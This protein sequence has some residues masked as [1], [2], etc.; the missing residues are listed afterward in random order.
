MEPAGQ[1]STSD[2]ESIR[3]LKAGYDTLKQE[4]HRVIVG[5]ERVLDEL[6]TAIFSRGHALLVGVPGLAKTLMIRTLSQTLSLSFNRVQFTPDLMPSDI[7]GTEVID[8][9]Q[10]V[11]A[12]ERI[13]MPQEYHRIVAGLALGP[14]NIVDI[15]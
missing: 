6:L 10:R 13:Y 1:V 3:K 2:L 9:A 5:Q 15:C 4:M 14:G 11:A 12:V 8:V 7:T